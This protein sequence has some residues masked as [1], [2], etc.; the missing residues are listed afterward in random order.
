MP[1]PTK[2]MN[3]LLIT[4]GNSPAI[5]PEA[6]HLPGVKFDEVRVLTSD[7]V[8]VKF[9]SEWFE[10][11]APGVRCEITRVA[12]F[13]DLQTEADHFRFEEVLYRWWIES[14]E[15]CVPHGLRVAAALRGAAED[16]QDACLYNGDTQDARSHKVYACLSGGFKTMSAAM[17]KAAAVL[18]AEEVFH[19]LADSVYTSPNEQ[20]RPAM[21]DAEIAECL[22]NGQIHWIRLGPESGWPQLRPATPAEYP[23][24][25]EAPD[26]A[27]IR[28]V[29]ALDKKFRSNLE[30]VVARSHHIA[31]SW[32]Q[33]S[34]FP[35]TELATWQAEDLAWLHG[36]LDPSTDRG[37]IEKLPKIEL[38]CHLGGFATSGTD[39]DT[40]RAAA[41]SAVELPEI[42]S[43]P[44][45]EGW[46]T[47]S[48]PCTL[49]PYRKLGDN[50]GSA[51]LR[52]KGCL[53]EQCHRLY[54][55]LISQKIA[56]AEIRCSPANYTTQNRSPWEVLCNIKEFFDECMKADVGACVPHGSKVAGPL[57]GAAEPTH[58]TQ[59]VPFDKSVDFHQTWRDLPHRHQV[60][61]TAFVTFR[62]A[63]SL[64]EQR[65]K[66]WIQERDQ[67]LRKNPKPWSQEQW[68]QF[69]REFP[70]KLETWL[71]EA[72]GFCPLRE[73]VASKI[74]ADAL[75][76]FDGERY[77]LDAFVIMPNHV[78][79]IFK[80]L[81]DHDVTA[82]LHS[83]KSYTAK[84]INE[85]TGRT[86]SLWQHES[87]D[88]LIRSADQMEALRRY[89]RDNPARAGLQD[90]FRLGC[91]SGL[92]TAPETGGSTLEPCETHAPTPPCRVNLIVIGTRKADGDYRAGI[93]RHLALAVTA[94][95]HWRSDTGC[96][97]VG[98]DLAG[99]EDESTRAHYFRE[100]FTAIHRCGLALTVHA[101][102]NDDAEGIW[103]AVFDLNTRR[104]GHAL[105]LEECPELLRSVAA[106]G[107]G[108]EMCPYA[109]FQIKGFLPMVGASRYPLKKYLEEGV[110][111]TVN[112]DNI[113]IS[114]ATLTD[115]FLFLTTLCP[116]LT[117]MDVLKLLRNAIDSAFLPPAEKISLLAGVAAQIPRP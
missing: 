95:D 4:L 37:W 23:L 79:A 64:P 73:Q 28:R 24:V 5:V 93:A 15:A 20:K 113:G 88:H 81:K 76:H 69:D 31:S 109:N 99:Y 21:T 82:I 55:H 29:R 116:D 39:L 54:S 80:P 97:V 94:A 1:A 110:K 9:V 101:G 53:R 38:H 74:L 16:T 11:N 13:T 92:K 72:H 45:P 108:V 8:N 33:I 49:E 115:N 6:F 98:V 47:P 50:N 67:F 36:A 104:L 34:D 87:F 117:R 56:Y 77:I 75:H 32:N 89:I 103:S 66:R 65:L 70:Q 85:A 63:D 84:K 12:G 30:D 57:W 48:A 42:K 19:V 90:G 43:L 41:K 18:G 61:A 83:W 44:Q 102:E 105:H 52:D 86:G 40:I 68:E 25:T 114:S 22:Q 27:G 46:P 112:T 3:L 2:S 7:S 26:A 96:C 91:G 35:F 60:D 107:I 17:Q 62:L 100:E 106:R 111:V 59:F 14:V 58:H 71:D 10:K 78:H 51:L